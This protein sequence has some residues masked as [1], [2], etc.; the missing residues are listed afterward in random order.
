MADPGVACGM[1]GVFDRSACIDGQFRRYREYVPSGIDCASPA[2]LILFL[3]G[4]GGNLATGD[5]ARAV[6]DAV[7]AVF[8]SPQGVDQGGA[9]GFGPDRIP[10]TQALITMILDTLQREFPTDP[11]FTV[12]TGFSNGGVFASYAIAWYNS[13]LAGVGVFASG[14]AEDITADL[15]A[16]PAKFPV[17]V[18]V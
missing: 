18:R 9:L 6:A 5:S 4:L 11:A 3:H 13:R 7:G 17:V 1:T 16:A 10:N 15:A 2:P 8:V 14:L 12:L